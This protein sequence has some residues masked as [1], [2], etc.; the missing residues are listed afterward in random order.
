MAILPPSPRLQVC[1]Y[2]HRR[3]HPLRSYLFALLFSCFAIPAHA[4][5]CPSCDPG[6]GG[7]SNTPPPSPPPPQVKITYAAIDPAQ[8]T[9]ELKFS[10]G[11]VTVIDDDLNK[12]FLSGGNHSSEMNLSTVLLSWANGNASK[13]SAMRARIHDMVS[14]KVRTSK[15]VK[16]A[17]I[18][19]LMMG[20]PGG[21]NFICDY[22]FACN[23]K[24]VPDIGGGGWGTYSFGF[25]SEDAAPPVGSDYN[26]WK[27]FR[28]DA[29]DS[30]HDAGIQMVLGTLG[31]VASCP[32]AATG[33]G[34]VG[35]FAAAITVIDGYDKYSAKGAVCESA[36]PGLG[37]W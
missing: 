27:H 24:A 21:N 13:A 31:G 25:Y 6:D 29:C 28:D 16:G 23:I 2:G 26:Y 7:G 32:F 15:L 30:Q 14:T 3:R 10:N 33:V 12:A 11:L 1:H 4:G 5:L 35:C 18:Q 34:A 37:N 20:M 22:S 17:P 8:G 9:V 36:Y 19:G